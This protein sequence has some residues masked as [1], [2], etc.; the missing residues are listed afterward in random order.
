MNT[1]GQVDM[2]KLFFWSCP[3]YDICMTRLKFFEYDFQDIGQNANKAVENTNTF[4]GF[5]SDSLNLQFRMI[6]GQKYHF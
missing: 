5:T 6:T 2:V 4:N 3:A 1:S